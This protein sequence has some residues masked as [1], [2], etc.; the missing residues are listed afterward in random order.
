MLRRPEPALS[1]A[2]PSCLPSHSGLWS[3]VVTLWQPAVEDFSQPGWCRLRAY[4]QGQEEGVQGPP[5]P[6]A[7][8]GPANGKFGRHRHPLFGWLGF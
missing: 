7:P 8:P 4:F 3:P 2:P 5:P 1:Q 6:L